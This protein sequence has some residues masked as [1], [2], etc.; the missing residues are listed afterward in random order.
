M[1]KCYAFE[2]IKERLANE[3]E[4]YTNLA[5][6]SQ[7]DE[8]RTTCA[9]NIKWARHII[10]YMIN[11]NIRLSRMV[12]TMEALSRINE[13]PDQPSSSYKNVEVEAMA[14]KALHLCEAD[15]YRLR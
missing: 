9:L 10:C 15:E 5:H 13:G 4:K 1:K 7:N 6:E 3:I 11:E 8:W 2:A 14:K 12:N